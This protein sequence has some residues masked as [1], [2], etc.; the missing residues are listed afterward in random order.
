MK[1]YIIYLVDCKDKAS[2]CEDDITRH[3]G[4]CYD[5][6]TAKDTCCDSCKKARLKLNDPSKKFLMF[7]FTD[8]INVQGN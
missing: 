5:E 6:R 7:C 1:T 8:L 2:W 3:S 4:W